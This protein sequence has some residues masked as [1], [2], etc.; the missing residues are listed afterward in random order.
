VK[1]FQGGVRPENNGQNSPEIGALAK[2]WHSRRGT[3]PKRFEQDCLK[4]LTFV[5]V[6]FYEGLE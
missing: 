5:I 4:P 6:T 2:L 1:S 3:S